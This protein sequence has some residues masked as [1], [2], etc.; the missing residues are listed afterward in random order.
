MPLAAKYTGAIGFTRDGRRFTMKLDVDAKVTT[1][2]YAGIVP[3]LETDIVATPERKR[4]V[5][6]RDFLLKDIAPPIR[7][8]TDGAPVPP[9]T[10]NG[11]AAPTP[12]RDSK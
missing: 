1:F 5:D 9:P 11:S 12:P 7:R 2:G 4:E 10:G 6:E 8:K 3:P